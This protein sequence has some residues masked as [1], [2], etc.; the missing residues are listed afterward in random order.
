M[1]LLVCSF[2]AGIVLVQQFTEI[3]APHEIAF[4]CL[5]SLGCAYKRFW[6]LSVFIGGILWMSLFASYRLNAQ[7]SE[8]L[9]GKDIQVEGYISS[10]P[11]KNERQIRFDFTV[12][13]SPEKL[14]D[15]LR[16]SWYS[17]EQ[18]LKAGQYWRFTVKLKR[19]HGMLNP[20]GFDYERWLFTQGIGATGYIRKAETVLITEKNQKYGINLWRQ[21]IADKLNDILVNNENLALIEALSIGERSQI[22]EQ[23]WQLFRK[24]G[25]VHLLAISGLH[26][27]LIA[28]LVFFLI[29]KLWALTGIFFI[30]SQSIAAFSASG[31]ALFYAA[32]AGFSIPTQRALIMVTVAMIAIIYQRHIRL[33]TVLSWALLLVLLF[34]PLAVLSGGFWLSFSAVMIILYC[35]GK[36]L[37][38]ASHFFKWIKIHGI[39][40]LGLSPLLLFFFQQ[41]S[42]ISP[43][44]NFMAIPFVSLLVVPLILCAIIAM[45]LQPWFAVQLFTIV[46]N[47]LLFLFKILEKLAQLPFAVFSLP[48]PSVLT[49]LLAVVGILL[50]LA[51][52]GFPAKNIGFIL[53]LPLLIFRQES[54]KV[55]EFNMALLDV[56]QG[57]A[58]VIQTSHHVLVFDSGAK[59]SESFDMGKAVLLP[60]LQSINANKINT[61]IISHGDNDHI[62]G[63]QSLI[64]NIPIDNVYSSVNR[65]INNIT[66]LPCLAGQS[67]QWDGVNFKMLSPGK[68]PFRSE[69]DNSCVLKVESNYGSVLLT[70]D[71]EARAENQLIENFE[72]TLKSDVLIAPHHGSNTSSS[73]AF[74][75][76]VKPEWIL[77]PTGYKNRFR[78]PHLKV[79]Q[80]YQQ[81]GGKWFSTANDGALLVD[82]RQ[83]K[84][85]ITSYRKK[86]EKYWNFHQKP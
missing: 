19:P 44:A 6:Y 39:L 60:Y 4:L 50:L 59:Y 55:G 3:P 75:K 10:L 16:L 34:D 66:A 31:V 52:K 15:K 12:I 68:K 51:P 80:R 49:V 64:N 38:R 63:M 32:L 8:K 83:T 57:L 43:I 1:P 79:L 33:S 72:H 46:D 61:L 13:S 24:T 20:A 42:L 5:L 37:G 76:T 84:R 74:L 30:S 73:T 21:V 25:I 69:N 22:S 70:G 7:L 65:S 45:F 53:L 2:L 78:F 29:R 54:L 56:G 26:I 67:W 81:Q 40:A 36:R 18:S 71:I 48:Q 86:T 27:G 85:K 35:S 9:E 14:P 11:Q 28:G 77:I 58:G 62:G 47:I 82:I 17:T 41:V 23:Q